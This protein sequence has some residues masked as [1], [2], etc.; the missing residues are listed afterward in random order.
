MSFVG[1]MW[2][3]VML[4]VSCSKLVVKVFVIVSCAIRQFDMYKLCIKCCT[5][6]N[7]CHS[8]CYNGLP[9]YKCLICYII[10]R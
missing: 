1:L 3:I 9:V 6:H 4:R 10:G 5:V 2:R 7:N 8:T